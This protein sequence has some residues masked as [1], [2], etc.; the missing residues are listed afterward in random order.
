MSLFARCCNFFYSLLG[1][2]Y[3][4]QFKIIRAIIIQAKS[5]N[6]LP[7]TMLTAIGG[8]NKLASTKI[9][10]M[11][12]YIIRFDFLLLL[13]DSYDIVHIIGYLLIQPVKRSFLIIE[14]RFENY[15]INLYLIHINY[16]YN[17]SRSSLP[18]ITIDMV[19][20]NGQYTIIL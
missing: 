17:I 15:Y 1:F 12:S 6:N 2:Y 8:L 20:G 10:S 19:L 18:T 4:T 5:N 3:S 11:F 9:L 13:V 7:L 16:K 14:F